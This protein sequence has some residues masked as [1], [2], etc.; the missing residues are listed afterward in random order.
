MSTSHTESRD[1]YVHVI[2]SVLYTSWKIDEGKLYRALE[3]KIAVLRHS[4]FFWVQKNYLKYIA[5][6]LKILNEMC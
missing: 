1:S 6:F 4:V 5:L 2:A 3:I